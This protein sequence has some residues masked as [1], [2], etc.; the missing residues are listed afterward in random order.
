MMFDNSGKF[1]SPEEIWKLAETVEGRREIATYIWRAR[2][3]AS[4]Q[5]VMETLGVVPD[6][7]TQQMVCEVIWD[8]IFRT[9][10]FDIMAYCEEI[11]EVAKTS[12]IDAMGRA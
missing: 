1:L 6:A 2:T 5:R 3:A 4:A 7:A 11:A 8:T 10:I 12:D 9:S